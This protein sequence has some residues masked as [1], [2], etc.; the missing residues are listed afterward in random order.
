MILDRT[1][2]H[3]QGGGQPNDEG[4]IKHRDH[5]FKFIVTNLLIKNDVIQHIGHFEPAEGVTSFLKGS[6]VECHLDEA[7]RR[8]YARVHSAGHLLDIAMTRAGRPDLKPSKGFHFAAGAYVEYIG[9]VGEAD[10][11]PLVDS[12]N[13]IAREIIEG[14]PAEQ[15]VFKKICSYDEANQHL[16]KAGGVPEYIPKG[17]DLRVLKL[18]EDD[19]GCPCG[20]THVQHVSDIEE[21]KI[22]KITKKGKAI[23]VAYV[24]KGAS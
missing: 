13:K 14:T 12:L 11:K 15:T 21:L 20:G 2:F 17:S 24:V 5:D 6:A 9:E 19:N 18:T 4:F 1:I 23:R 3:P 16:A 10:R 8:L 22:T 7:K